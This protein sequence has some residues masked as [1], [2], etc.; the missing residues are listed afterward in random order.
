VTFNL[1]EFAKA[2]PILAGI[3]AMFDAALLEWIRRALFKK[4][5]GPDT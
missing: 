2:N 4:N 5:L 3:L 1:L